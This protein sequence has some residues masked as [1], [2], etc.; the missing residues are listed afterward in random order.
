MLPYS[1]EVLFSVIAQM[2]AELWPALILA[3]AAGGALLVATWSPVA[4]GR[5]GEAAVARFGALVLAAGWIAAAMIFYGHY[6]E[7]LFFGAVW[8]QW[9]FMGQGALLILA[10]VAL[11]QA[12][13]ETAGLALWFGRLLMLYALLGMPAVDLMLGPGWP[14]FRVIGL[15][16]EPTVVLTCGWL[17]TRR[18]GWS[19]PV[20]AIIPAGA[21]VAAAYSALAL[22][23][24]PDWIVLGAALAVLGVQ[25]IA[26]GI[27]RTRRRPAG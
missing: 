11:P 12:S 14:A 13:R 18:F 4:A 20:L 25:P 7:P 1:L 21:G 6:L 16:S 24:P 9:G 19:T 3:G 15:A 2:N 8:F 5:P 22:D 10:A 27:R 26:A 23:W 17:L